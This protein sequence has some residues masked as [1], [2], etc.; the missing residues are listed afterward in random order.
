MGY[1]LNVLRSDQIDNSSFII[2]GQGRY[3][4]QRLCCNDNG[5]GDGDDKI[6]TS[7]VQYKY[8]RPRLTQSFLIHPAK[9]KIFF[10][11]LDFAILVVHRHDVTGTFH[12]HIMISHPKYKILGPRDARTL[13]FFTHYK[14]TKHNFKY[15]ICA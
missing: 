7:T 1:Q 2:T 15:S 14:S 4:G 3:S 10:R 8:R 12:Q 9:N 13:T 6:V 5:D 11:I